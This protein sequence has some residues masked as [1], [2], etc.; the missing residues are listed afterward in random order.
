MNV[1]YT[2][3]MALSLAVGVVIS[4][5]TQAKLPLTVPQRLAIAA[6]AIGGAALFA[7]LPF[8]FRDLEAL[9]SGAVW[10]DNGRTLTLGLLGGY[11]GVEAAKWA[12]DVRVRTGDG[13]VVPVAASVAVGRLGCFV[14]GCCFGAATTVPWA[15]DF[16]DGVLRHPTQLYEA[17]FH[18]CAAVG[19]YVL[20]RR[21]VWAGHRFKAYVLA[22]LAFRFGTEWVR[23][24]E[25]GVLGLTVYQWIVL[26]EVPVFAGLWAAGK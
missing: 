15:H 1:A 5:L 11:V 6:G 24:E 19:L 17:A 14:G 9:R 2:A 25:R 16:G 26:A 8:L 13:F 12:A 22:Y 10:L 21:G 4:R 7:K 23:P 20:G 18:A 3:L